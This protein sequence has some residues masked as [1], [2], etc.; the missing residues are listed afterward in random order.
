MTKVGCQTLRIEHF[1][2]SNA[3]NKNHK[4]TFATGLMEVTN[5]ILTSYPEGIWKLIRW[6]GNKDLKNQRKH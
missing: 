6:F 2:I 3:C 5:L 1:T 4:L